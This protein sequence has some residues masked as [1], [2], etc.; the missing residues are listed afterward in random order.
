MFS[1]NPNVLFEV[2]DVYK[3]YGEA[4]GALAVL[5][6]IIT[7]FPKYQKLHLVTHSAA[8]VLFQVSVRALHP[9]PLLR[10]RRKSRRF[11]QVLPP[12]IYIYFF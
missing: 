11:S 4:L 5:S 1:A 10:S 6:Q 8:V 2:A 3:Q 9:I 7:T 12:Y